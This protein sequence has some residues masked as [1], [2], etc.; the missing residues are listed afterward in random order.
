MI[1]NNK[2]MLLYAVTD[3]SW[4]TEQADSRIANGAGKI[5]NMSCAGQLDDDAEGILIK[6]VEEAL[7]GGITCLQLRE[8]ELT[9]EL[10]L[11]EALKIKQLCK[12]YHVPFIINDD[13]EIALRS[14]ADGV[15]VGQ[16]D[17]RVK[18]ARQILG[19]DVIIGVSV[20][21]VNQ[22][23]SAQAE[24]A[25][26][27]GVG[28]IFPTPTKPDA[29]L[30]SLETLRDICA[31]VSIPV[32]AI[33]GING[34]NMVKLSDT[35]VDGV[36]L[37][38]AIFA[39]RDIVRECRKLKGLAGKLFCRNTI[40]DKYGDAIEIKGAIFDMDGTLLD[41]MFIWDNIAAQY[42]IDRG[43]QP[44]EKI[45]EKFRSMS[46]TQ[47]AQYYEERYDLKESVAE[48]ESGINKMVENFY[49]N[50]V[51][52]KDG[53]PELLGELASLGIRMC[54]A[55]AT[56]KR[57]AEA[58]IRRCGFSE[59]FVSI[60][61][62]GEMGSGKDNPEI[63]YE[64]L[65]RLGTDK[66]STPVFEDADHALATA[67]GAGFSTIGIYDKSYEDFQD[68]IEANSSLYIK[69]F[70]DLKLKRG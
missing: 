28:A 63:F 29:E 13:V 54:V 59:Y 36:A 31:A 39:S 64:A 69:S 22:A 10:F 26:Y 60:I 50:E 7:K 55:T 47:A 53:V 33:G 48:I 25:D 12:Q 57:L 24:G 32:V 46:L 40:I 58:A 21:D 19:S 15:H 18:K 4:C 2:H 45:N 66:K 49:F 11:A 61:T 34:D 23:L 14:G 67:R 70:R 17:M 30:V 1:I 52:P 37:V 35:G 41:S 8:K 38:S 9:P 62:C 42:L 16:Q 5:A 65:R 68:D 20:S 6:Q 56:D 51:E 44:E 27:L 43:I 3:R